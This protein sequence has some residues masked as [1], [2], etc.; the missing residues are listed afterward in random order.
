MQN[1][2]SLF[3]R[4]DE[5]RNRAKPKQAEKQTKQMARE[6]NL[7]IINQKPGPNNPTASHSQH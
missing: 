5:Q 7:S 1:P 6:H 2:K 4:K 3:S